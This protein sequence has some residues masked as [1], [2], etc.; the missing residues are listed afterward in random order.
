[1][2]PLLSER[3][4]EKLLEA[5]ELHSDVVKKFCKRRI[6]SRG[7]DELWAGDLLIMSKFAGENKGYNYVLNIIDTFSKYMFLQPLKTT[8]GPEVAAAFEK[9]IEKSGRCPKLLH[10]DRGKEFVN[11]DFKRV[12]AKYAVKMSVSYTHLTLPT[13]YSV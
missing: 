4:S 2:A 8:S 9:I 13:I 3:I 5:L 10:V 6:V 1:M 11:K 12:L 7:I